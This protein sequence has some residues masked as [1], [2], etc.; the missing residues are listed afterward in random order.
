MH[1]SLSTSLLN[2]LQLPTQVTWPPRLFV[3]LHFD[4]HSSQ[5]CPTTLHFAPLYTNHYSLPCLTTSHIPWLLTTLPHYPHTSPHFAPHL[6]PQNSC[7]ALHYITL[8]PSHPSFPSHTP[9][10]TWKR[11]LWHQTTERTS[12]IY[13]ETYIRTNQQEISGTWKRRNVLFRL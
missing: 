10:N 7:T 1:N 8:C 5:F 3:I 4:H 13:I 6:R 2:H 12:I 11:K 9:M